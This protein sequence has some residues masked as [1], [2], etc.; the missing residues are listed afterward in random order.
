MIGGKHPTPRSAATVRAVP[1][2]RSAAGD[3]APRSA[4]RMVGGKHHLTRMLAQR[5]EVMRDRP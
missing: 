1:T 3:P 4:D 2:P 5:E